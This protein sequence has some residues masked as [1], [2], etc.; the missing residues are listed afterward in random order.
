MGSSVC[1]GAV[2]G[3]SSAGDEAAGRPEAD[4]YVWTRTTLFRALQDL[5]FSFSKGPNHYDAVREKLSFI[6][7]REAL[8]DTLR[9]YR[10]KRNVLY[11]TEE[12]WAKK[13]CR[14]IGAGTI[15]T[16]SRDWTCRREKG[17]RMIIAHVGS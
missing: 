17:G 1:G 10:E 11:Y 6:R 14:S 15:G 2:G 8:V 13:I 5:G 4:S 9:Q 16:S 3:G 12:T 7:Q